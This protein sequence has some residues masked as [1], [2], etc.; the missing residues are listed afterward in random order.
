MAV[1]FF[2]LKKIKNAIVKIVK[3][4]SF[5]SPIFGAIYSA[6]SVKKGA[7]AVGQPEKQGRGE[8]KRDVQ[9]FGEINSPRALQGQTLSIQ[10]KNVSFPY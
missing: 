3:T 1:P 6:A 7:V 9:C 10:L 8:G 2:P 4:H 5:M